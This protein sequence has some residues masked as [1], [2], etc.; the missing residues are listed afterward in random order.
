MAVT[1]VFGLGV[2]TL[3][4]LIVVPVLYSIFFGIHK[5]KPNNP[6]GEK[7]GIVHKQPGSVE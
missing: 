6:E 5:D 4:I 2:A 1:I 7:P 3:L